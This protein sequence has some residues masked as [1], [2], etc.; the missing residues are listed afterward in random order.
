MDH[1]L[2]ILT[3]AGFDPRGF[4]RA[5]AKVAEALAQ[6]GFHAAQVKKLHHATPAASPTGR[7]STIPFSDA[8]G[9]H[10]QRAGRLWSGARFPARTFGACL[11]Q[12]ARYHRPA[13]S[14]TRPLYIRPSR[15][16]R[17]QPGLRL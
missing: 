12:V 14:Q 9:P 17:D 7:G 6:G 2:E 16:K 5:Y 8:P 1:S 13:Q 11:G 15:P 10:P 4:E 3:Y